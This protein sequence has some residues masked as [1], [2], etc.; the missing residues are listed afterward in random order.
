MKGWLLHT[1][2][3]KVLNVPVTP[4]W[5]KLLARTPATALF[6]R[7][8]QIQSW[9]LF[10]PAAM[11]PLLPFFHISLHNCV[12]GEKECLFL[13]LSLVCWNLR[14]FRS[15]CGKRVTF[16]ILQENVF[17]SHSPRG[18]GAGPCGTVS[19]MPVSWCGDV[20]LLFVSRVN[21]TSFC[22]DVDALVALE[23][24][25][26]RRAWAT[27]DTRGRRGLFK[28]CVVFTVNSLKP[29]ICLSFWSR[30]FDLFS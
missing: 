6:S 3:A 12:R 1:S 14:L 29:P 25:E 8:I 17:R 27:C 15:W 21:S 16:P 30:S 4:G 13:I 19:H 10:P 24:T 7:E 23:W 28:D 9:L 5:F 22:V 20:K 26:Q 2:T 18:T 11:N